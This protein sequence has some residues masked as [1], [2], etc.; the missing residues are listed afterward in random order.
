MT[1]PN[2]S[3]Q[4]KKKTCQTAD[5]AVPTNHRIKRKENENRD[6]YLDV[7]KKLKK[8]IEDEFDGDVTC[9]WRNRSSHQRIGKETE[10]VGNKRTGGDHPNFRNVEIN[11]NTESL[12]LAVTHTSVENHQFMLV[13]KFSKSK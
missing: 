7:I 9:N 3:Q 2:D 4:N 6:K 12:K 13:C 10:G 1:R 11:Q 5:F 8:T